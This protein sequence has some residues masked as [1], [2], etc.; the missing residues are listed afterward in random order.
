MWF[1]SALFALQCL[2]ATWSLVPP[3]DFALM[4]LYMG[5]LGRNLDIK[6]NRKALQRPSAVKGLV[7]EE[8]IIGDWSQDCSRP[9]DEDDEKEINEEEDENMGVFFVELEGATL[10]VRRIKKKR[11]LEDKTQ[12]LR[13][14][15]TCSACKQQGHIKSNRKCSQWNSGGV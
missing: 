4:V 7:P 5:A 14:Q 12:K 2:L 10:Q 6:N 9:E 11:N 8:L 1:L 13:R 3:T 15:T